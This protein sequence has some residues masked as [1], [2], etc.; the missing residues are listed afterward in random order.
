DSSDLFYIALLEKVIYQKLEIDS[1]KT[2]AEKQL[3]QILDQD[4]S[5]VES[6]F[7]IWA[8]QV[9]DIQSSEET[10]SGF[11][12]DV[13]NY[14]PELYLQHLNM[15]AYVFIEYLNLLWL[16]PTEQNKKQL[17]TYIEYYEIDEEKW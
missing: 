8:K 14:N 11:K 6:E 3:E 16:N 12:I 17:Q 13:F 15:R 1:H 5:G 4:I 7:M 10:L 9:V 2:I